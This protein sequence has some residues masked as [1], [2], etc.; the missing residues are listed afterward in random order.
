MA[1]S[2]LFLRELGFF[3]CSATKMKSPSNVFTKA[4]VV[5]QP[6]LQDFVL[7]NIHQFGLWGI[8]MTILN[9]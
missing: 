3:H 8:H 4:A 9:S 6:H 5:Y 2:A 7:L 1:I